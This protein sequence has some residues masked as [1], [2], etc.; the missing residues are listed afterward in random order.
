MTR[1]ADLAKEISSKNAG[2]FAITFDI[3][4]DDASTYTRVKDAGVITREAVADAYR[5]PLEDVLHVVEFDQGNAFKVAVRRSHPSGSVG[6]TDVFGA[7]QYAPLL[8]FEVP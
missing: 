8:D 7:Q 6:E 1:L 5:M 2:A 3:V 4:F